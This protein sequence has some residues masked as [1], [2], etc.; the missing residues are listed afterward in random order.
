M[1]DLPH[2]PE[3]FNTLRSGYHYTPEDGAVYLA[4]RNDFD[5][6]RDAFDAFGLTLRMHRQQVVY[7]ESGGSVTPGKQAREMGLFMMILIEWMG[8]QR[9]SIVPDLFNEVFYIHALP[10]LQNA[11]YSEYMNAVDVHDSSDLDGIVSK[12][13]SFG[14]AKSVGDGFSFREAAYRFLDL[15]QDVAALDAP[16]D[17][18]S[19]DPSS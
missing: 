8:N 18:S 7:L 5:R 11:R 13:K 17:D 2:L 10:H 12:L 14:F 9:A 1:T 6:Y 4:L 16:S 3:I 19:D 15:C